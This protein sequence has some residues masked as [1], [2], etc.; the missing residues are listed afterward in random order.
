MATPGGWSTWSDWSSCSK[1][2]QGNGGHQIRNRMCS[3]PLPANRGAY[4]TGYSF[5]QRSCSSSSPCTSPVDGG[6]SEW[7]AW[8]ECSDP[9]NNGHKSRTRWVI[10]YLILC[11]PRF[12]SNPRPS[13]GGQQCY[14]SDFELQPCS[15]PSKCHCESSPSKQ[16]VFLS[17]LSVST[18]APHAFQPSTA[19]G[20]PGPTGPTAPRLLVASPSRPG[21]VDARLP[22]LRTAAK[23]VS[24]T[25][26]S[27]PSATPT[28]VMVSTACACFILFAQNGINSVF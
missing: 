21:T 25:G 16:H 1:D 26:C 14:G 11:F 7:T 18:L 8:S 12:C 6:W 20:P 10:P 2:C 15:D 23:N 27:R 19:T 17:F 24:A 28:S 3:E 4:C 5:D 13:H 9:C 22:L